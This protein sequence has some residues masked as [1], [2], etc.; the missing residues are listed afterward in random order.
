MS[1][2]LAN[3]LKEAAESDL[4]TFIKLVAPEQVLGACHEEVIKWWYRPEASTH[5]LLLF[6]P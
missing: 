2:G 5:Q 6:P 4:L 3:E 1:K